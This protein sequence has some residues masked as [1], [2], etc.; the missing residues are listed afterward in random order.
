MEATRDLFREL[1]EGFDA[2]KG[3]RENRLPLR[4]VRVEATPAAP[5]GAQAVPTI[6]EKQTASS[7]NGTA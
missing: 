7:D 3:Q 1:A 6:A 5:R 4:T 2:L